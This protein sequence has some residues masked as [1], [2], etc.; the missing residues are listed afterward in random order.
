MVKRH[1][2][3]I[4]IGAVDL[5]RSTETAASKSRQARFRSSNSQIVG[6]GE[7]QRIDLL[8]TLER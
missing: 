8:V 6:P 7:Y 1:Q 3:L 4:E 5:R 2:K